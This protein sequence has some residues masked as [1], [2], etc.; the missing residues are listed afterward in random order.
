MV[1]S[2][3]KTPKANSQYTPVKHAPPKR[4]YEGP[5]LQAWGSILELTGGDHF[6]FSDAD[7]N[8]GSTAT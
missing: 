6:T 7:M 5:K 2:T 3:E 1:K 8:G 4:P